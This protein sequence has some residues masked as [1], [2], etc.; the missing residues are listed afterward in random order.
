VA[1]QTGQREAA[2]E[3]WRRAVELDR[4][5]YDALF[6]LGTELLNAGRNA[7]ARIYLE[8]FVQTAP[9]TFYWRE[10]EKIQRALR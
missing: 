4:T 5:N 9:R 3:H 7:E 2:I 6:N 1:I 8:R 10:V